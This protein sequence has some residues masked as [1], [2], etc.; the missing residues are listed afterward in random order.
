MGLDRIGFDRIGSDRIGSDRIGR[1]ETTCDCV[2]WNIIGSASD[3]IRERR[4]VM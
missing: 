1:D 4:I 3:L 2:G